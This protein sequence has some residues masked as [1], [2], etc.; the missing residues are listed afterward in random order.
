MSPHVAFLRGMNLGRR[1]ITNDELC[2]CFDELGFKNVAAF[3]ASGN[4]VFD[5]RTRG[6][7][8]ALEKRIEK[9]LLES[10]EYEVPTFVRD[11]D[12]LRAIVAHARFPAGGG[13]KRSRGKI[14]VAMLRDEPSSSARRTLHALS[15][16]E[17][18]LSIH[19]RELYWLPSGN[20]SDSELDLRRIDD[21]LGVMTI[22]TRRTIER[23]VSKFF[24]PE[25][26]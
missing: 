22:R 11:A 7:T 9:G 18:Q 16:R 4:V 13:A 12:E 6:T 10:L 17:D 3:L 2:A 26:P 24:G 23:I 1:R 25:Q 15:S 20:M 5:A 19:G 21:T 8:A 14:Q